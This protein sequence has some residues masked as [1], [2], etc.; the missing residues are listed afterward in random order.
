[1]KKILIPFIAG[2]LTSIALS[3]L[4]TEQV[5]F[6]FYKDDLSTVLVSYE[7]AYDPNKSSMENAPDY[8]K[9]I[10]K[11]RLGMAGTIAEYPFVFCSKEFEQLV[12]LAVKLEIDGARDTSCYNNNQ[13]ANLLKK[14]K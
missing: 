12:D 1:M 3:V 5:I 8:K 11:V 10:A 4:V 9:L 2:V 14:E 7:W 6:G 13:A